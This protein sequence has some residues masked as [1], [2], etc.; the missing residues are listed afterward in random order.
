MHQNFNLKHFP[1]G[2]GCCNAHCKDDF[3]SLKCKVIKR[4]YKIHN[5]FEGLNIFQMVRSSFDFINVTLVFDN[6][7]FNARKTFKP[8]KQNILQQISLQ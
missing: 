2:K 7:R 8:L 3:L 1:T 4:K 6:S 5:V